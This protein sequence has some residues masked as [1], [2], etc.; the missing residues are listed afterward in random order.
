MRTV[1]KPARDAIGTRPSSPGRIENRCP[2][3]FKAMPEA[4][5]YETLGIPRDATA[6]AI[7]KGYRAQARK[8]HPDVNP[9]D[10]TAEAKFKEVQQAYDILSETVGSQDMARIGIRR[11]RSV[12]VI[13]R[14]VR[15]V[16]DEIREYPCEDD[17]QNIGSA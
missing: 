15:V 9:G 6:D 7:K 8:F 5:Y 10:K 14:I 12:V 2:R 17:Q 1:K 11:Q 3:S 4:D 16:D 13:E